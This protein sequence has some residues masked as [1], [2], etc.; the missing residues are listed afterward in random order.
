MDCIICQEIKEDVIEIGCDVWMC[1]ACI[2]GIHDIEIPRPS[3][4]PEFK[5]YTYTAVNC[6][7]YLKFECKELNVAFLYGYIFKPQFHIYFFDKVFLDLTPEYEL[8]KMVVSVE[9]VKPNK[10]EKKRIEKW[11][12]CFKSHADK[13][14]V[15]TVE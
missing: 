4:V 9:K 7:E 13:W 2:S 3:R 11:V 6:H 14:T 15:T 1:P 8:E 12:E 5:E 10:E